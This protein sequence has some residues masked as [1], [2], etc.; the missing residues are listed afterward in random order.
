MSST[1]YNGVVFK[2]KRN[3]PFNIRKSLSRWKGL[4]ARGS[5]KGFCEF[6]D[7][8]YGVRAFIILIH[9]YI[10]IKGLRTVRQIVSTYAPKSEN[11]TEGYIRYVCFSTG[12]D[13]DDVLKDRDIIDL[14]V[15]MSV[16]EGNP[17]RKDFITKVFYET[18]SEK[19]WVLH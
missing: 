4:T 5:E 18:V 2:C 14:G 10:H 1:D 13:D 3:N 9:N 19:G 7:V 16:M 15:A 17:I 8:C 6:V 12:F 11:D